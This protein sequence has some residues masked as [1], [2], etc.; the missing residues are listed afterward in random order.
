MWRR[1]AIWRSNLD[2]LLSALADRAKADVLV[3]SKLRDLGEGRVLLSYRAVDVEDGTIVAATSHRALT[4]DPEDMNQ[5]ALVM[6]LDDA[7]RDAVRLMS[8]R[9]EDLESPPSTGH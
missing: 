1:A 8:D 7:L 6:R 2:Q 5:N 4:M 3:V 9:A